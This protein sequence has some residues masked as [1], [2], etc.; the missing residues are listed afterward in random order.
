MDAVRINKPIIASTVPDRLTTTE[1]VAFG[2]QIKLKPPS[3]TINGIDIDASQ[4][5]DIESFL[6]H[7]KMKSID[8]INSQDIER[9]TIAKR[10]K[11]MR[12]G[13]DNT[14]HDNKGLIFWEH[15]KDQQLAL[16]KMAEIF[17]EFC[18][19]VL[20]NMERGGTLLYDFLQPYISEATK[21]NFSITT[22]KELTLSS[23]KHI[24]KTVSEM[25]KFSK[26]GYKSF[27]I[28]EVAISGAQLFKILKTLDAVLSDDKPEVHLIILKQSLT[29]IDDSVEKGLNEKVRKILTTN[30]HLH[31]HIFMTPFIVGEDVHEHICYGVQNQYPINLILPDE[32]VWQLISSAGTRESLKRIMS[33][34]INPL[35]SSLYSE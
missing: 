6:P 11:Q 17:N 23:T 28:V 12:K 26:L 3:I 16:M 13:R 15:V 4:V 29:K 27:A 5:T 22:A 18:I 1:G 7:V 25:C 14:G 24:E 31:L 8:Y 10:I 32:S 33:G 21:P 20:F 9:R 2:R 35:I 34:D 19:E 30:D